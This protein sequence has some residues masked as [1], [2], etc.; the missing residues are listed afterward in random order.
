MRKLY[1]IAIALL[2]ALPVAATADP[3]PSSSSTTYKTPVG[4]ITHHQTSTP[5]GN[6]TYST[7]TVTPG[8]NSKPSVYVGTTTNNPT[9]NKSQGTTVPHAGV[10]VPF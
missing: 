4:D 3:T 10:A 9:P 8:N 5:M 1:A 6:G 7:N 2:A